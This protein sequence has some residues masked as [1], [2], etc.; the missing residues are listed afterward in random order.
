M[1]KC[2]I[3]F[4]KDDSWIKKELEIKKEEASAF[5]ANKHV[6]IIWELPNRFENFIK[7]KSTLIEKINTNGT[8]YLGEFKNKKYDK[9]GYI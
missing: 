2:N 6:D 8:K 9:L 7:S 1:R 4:V 3:K 5:D